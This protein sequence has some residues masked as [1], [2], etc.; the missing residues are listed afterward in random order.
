[1]VQKKILLTTDCQSNIINITTLK[2]EK[3][4]KGIFLSS[5]LAEQ[6][7]KSITVRG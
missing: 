7:E 1:M 5:C 2:P 3:K 4:E 6:L